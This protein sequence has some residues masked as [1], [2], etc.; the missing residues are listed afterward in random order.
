VVTVVNA[1]FGFFVIQDET[2]GIK[3]QSSRVVENSLAGHRVEIEGSNTDAGAGAISGSA[4][5]DLGPVVLPEPVSIT[6]KELQLNTFDSKRVM[7]AGTARIGHVDA[8]GQ[9]VIPMDVGGFEV[10]VRFMDDRGLDV[11][12]LVDAEILVTGV[13][14][15]SVDIDGRLTD[16]T[17]L[18]PDPNAVRMQRKA[19]DPASLAVQTVA[20]ITKAS[21]KVQEHRVRC[22]GLIE[23]GDETGGFRFRDSSG[24]IAISNVAGLDTGRASPVD[25]V[26]FV[27]H[28]NAGWQLTG[29]RPIFRTNPLAEKVSPRGPIKTVAELHALKAEEAA[30]ERA[31]LLE[32]VVTYFDP[33]WQM[34]FFQDR[35]GGVYISLHGSGSVPALWVG[36]RVVIRGFS[37]AGDFAPV[38]LRPQFHFIEHAILPAPSPLEA[39]TIFSG[40]AD[41]QWVELQGIVQGIGFDGNHPAAKLSWGVHTY[42]VIFPP[43]VKLTPEWIDARVNV[44]GAAGTLFNGGRQVLGIQLFVEGLDQMKRAPNSTRGDGGLPPVMPINNL[45]QFDPNEMPGHRV[46]LRGKVLASHAEGPTWIKDDSGAV[47]V[48]EHN[49]VVLRGG[50]VVD[51]F[52]FAFPGA[53]A[54]EIHDAQV[55]K[56]ARGGPV[57]PIDVTPERALFQGVHGQLVR[58]EG[59]LM[60][61]YRSGQEQALLLRSGKTTFTVRGMGNLPVYDNGAVLRFTGICSVSAKRYRGVLVPSSFEIAVD[62]PASVTILRNAPWLT[63]Q[64][65]WRVL[66]FTSFLIAAVLVWVL[67]LRR[68]V[69][70]QTRLIQQKLLEV[71]KLKQKAEAANEAK[72]QFLANMSHEIRTPMNGILGMTELAM[73]AES[74]EEQ[75]EYLS[76]LRSSGDA[77]LAIL[78]DLLDLSKIEAG[79]FEIERAP[80]SIRNL[81]LD[82]SKV[83]AYRMREKGLQFESSVADSLPDTLL[84]DALRLRQVLLNLLGN[85]VKFTHV[86][87]V[88]LLAT[89]ERD[90]DQVHLRLVVRDSGIGIPR[91]KQGRIFEAFRQADN[92]T[93]RKYGGTGLGLSICVKL[94]ALMEGKI[95][96]ESE[97]GQGSAFAIDLLLRV[98]PE[99]AV[100]ASGAT[101]GKLPAVMTPLNILLAEDNLVNQIVAAKLLKKQGHLVTVAGNGKLAVQEFERGAFDLI[102][103]D[104]QMP[105]MDGLEA[106]REIRLLERGRKTRVPIIALTAQTMEGD[107]EN[108]LRAGMDGFASKPIR[109]PE[110]WAAI[111]AAAAPATQ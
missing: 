46:H 77:L 81:I 85:A 7:L 103:M 25:V 51:V 49:E 35:T 1:N 20:E 83:F 28:D 73:Q 13:A 80:F 110:L 47:A 56:R 105:E 88:S 39:E 18:A 50:D 54:A 26:A 59:R 33:N 34:M 48:R 111:G 11:E 104:V 109:L 2:G 72:S 8:A 67:M 10:S 63:E 19:R 3:I 6:A 57:Q 65:A 36:D 74:A 100:A 41:S 108:C 22:R 14:S 79:K 30:L 76:T 96:V 32:G 15:T 24:S 107:R 31:V 45:L 17:I 91:E 92:L 16:L 40:A 62:S 106:A 99:S 75:R 5:R 12:Q 102:L 38:V 98:A 64:R 94:V 95:E 42:K 70:G 61:E 27:L 66:A 4:V 90:G 23:K 78:N 9:L 69:S 21:G 68:R 87:T 55:T 86:G 93:A 58:L 71:E 44:R 84:G 52:G 37:G 97:L 89:G 29:V 60:S 43:S 82:A 53:F 101:G